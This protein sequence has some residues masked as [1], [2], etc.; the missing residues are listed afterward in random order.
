MHTCICPKT[1]IFSHLN[2][3]FKNRTSSQSSTHIDGGAWLESSAGARWRALE[4]KHQETL[5]AHIASIS[6][7]PLPGPLLWPR[8]LA[9]RKKRPRQG[10]VIDECCPTERLFIDRSQN[11]RYIKKHKDDHSS[12]SAP[13]RDSRAV[14]DLDSCP[15]AQHLKLKI[16]S[17]SMAGGCSGIISALPLFPIIRQHDQLW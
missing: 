14:P 13:K 7:D 5:K 17:R 4:T 8:H 3:F 11:I 10:A 15:K 2:C 16:E 1:A 9:S 12:N 6:I